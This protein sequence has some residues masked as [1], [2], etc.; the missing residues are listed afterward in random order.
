MIFIIQVIKTGR[1]RVTVYYFFR[2][3]LRTVLILLKNEFNSCRCQDNDFNRWAVMQTNKS[4]FQ[5]IDKSIK[6]QRATDH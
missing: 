1:G 4:I 5:L 2:I 3:R 6:L